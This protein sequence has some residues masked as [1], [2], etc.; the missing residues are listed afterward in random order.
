M[1]VSEAWLL[2][3]NETMPIAI[4]DNEMME[5]VQDA[6]SY[7]VPGAPEYCDRIVL[8]QDHIAP[9]MDLNIMLNRPSDDSNR[10]M[11]LIAYQSQPGAALQYL[12]LKV[13]TPPRKIIVDD[14]QACEL[15]E[16][17]EEGP[18]NP[19]CLSCFTEDSRPVL[20]LDIAKLCSAEF[21]DYLNTGN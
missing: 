17:I 7:P 8:W 20:I 21:R 14:E 2:E 3:P 11:S 19:L 15:P 10:L 5:Y 6:A 9:V 18:L 4:G 1:T 12:A 13:R 16:D